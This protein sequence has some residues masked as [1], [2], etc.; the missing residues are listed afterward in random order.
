MELKELVDRTLE[1]FQAKDIEELG[2]NIKQ[3]CENHDYEK[4]EQFVKLINGDL[5]IDWIQKIF[6]YYVA[7]R[8]DKK[9]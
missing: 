1:L 4:M 9:H 7:D 8:K 2:K 3:V 6:Q 5:T